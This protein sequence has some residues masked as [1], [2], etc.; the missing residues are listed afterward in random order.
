M[1]GDLVRADARARKLD[2][3]S[4]Q[5]R[6]VSLFLGGADGELAEA[7]QL[8]SETDERVHDLDERRLAGATPHG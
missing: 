6:A 7:L 3:R 1:L 2:H 4:A 5:I 8:L